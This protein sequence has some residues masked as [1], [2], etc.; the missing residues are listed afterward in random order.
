[1]RFKAAAAMRAFGRAFGMVALNRA[2]LLG[3]VW[4]GNISPPSANVPALKFSSN[5]FLSMLMRW[6]SQFYWSIAAGGYNNL[7]DALQHR[8]TN[9]WPLFPWLWRA[10]HFVVPS[11]PLSGFLLNL[12]LLTVAVASVED[13]AKR[14]LPPSSARLAPL[15]FLAHPCAFYY[16]AYYTEAAFAC[17]STL[18]V[19]LAYR[20]CWAA[21]ALAAGFAGATRMVGVAAG[22][23]VGFA[24][25][26]SIRFDLRQ[27][28]RRVLWLPLVGGG[29]V[30]YCTY[31]FL[32]FHEP[33]A[34]TH[35]LHA[36]DWGA[37]VTVERLGQTVRTFFT[38]SAWPLPWREATDMAHLLILLFT[39]LV[40][41]AGIRWLRP[42][43]AIFAIVTV[44]LSCRYW[45]NAGRYCA[46]IFP[47]YFVLA[48]WLSP[49][50]NLQIFFVVLGLLGN[51]VV[52]W[53]YVHDFWV[54]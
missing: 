31:L 43:L 51:A 26:E 53:L 28:N 2:V 17:F 52:G 12:I 4:L 27:I 45:T 3:A 48:R 41:M 13:I 33:F 20:R 37:D 36:K 54:S 30:A 7:D 24:Y 49:R 15:L 47:S 34:F 35:G 23:A 29:T 38:Y 32:K 1:M 19:A 50:P 11:W 21:A 5:A 46:P 10:V 9:F 22:I 8:D 18:A 39:I 42:S 40:T 16:S 25:L 14:V 44:F 6:D